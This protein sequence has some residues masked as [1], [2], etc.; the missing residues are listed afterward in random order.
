ML[1]HSTVLYFR[2]PPITCFLS[3]NVYQI[4]MPLLL[5]SNFASAVLHCICLLLFAW[6]G[7]LIRL[8]HLHRLLWV[9]GGS[10][11]GVAVIGGVGR[12]KHRRPLVRFV[13]LCSHRFSCIIWGLAMAYASHFAL[14]VFVL[15]WW[16]CIT[17]VSQN[18]TR[19][20]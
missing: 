17:I 12:S 8:R 1:F 4:G 19:T 10:L 2:S 13:Q 20:C 14:V 15:C 3:W 18:S 9:F 11:N 7:S 16:T 6:P 5:S